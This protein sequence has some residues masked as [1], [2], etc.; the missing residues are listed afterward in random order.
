MRK[1]LACLTLVTLLVAGCAF[2]T[3]EKPQRMGTEPDTP[4]EEIITLKFGF[5]NTLD[6]RAVDVL[7]AAFQQA[8]PR[9]RVE[10]EEPK[11]HEIGHMPAMINHVKDR[12]FDLLDGSYWAWSNDYNILFEPLDT[13]VAKG[14]L[15]LQPCGGSDKAAL[16][17]GKLWALPLTRVPLV[18]VANKRLLEAEGLK[19]PEQ[20]WTWEQFRLAAGQL[21]H[22]QGD[23]KVWGFVTNLP[24]AM[25]QSW[26]EELSGKPVW[27]SDAQQ[28]GQA[29]QFFHSMA[30]T[31]RSVF[32]TP[33]FQRGHA[34]SRPDVWAMVQSGQAA[35]GLER[36]DTMPQGSENL[37]VLP[38]PA[39]DPARRVSPSYFSYVAMAVGT[40]KPDDAWKFIQFAL[41]PQGGEVLA[42]AGILPACPTE[43]ARDAWMRRSPAPPPATATFFTS[44]WTATT[45]AAGHMSY[46]ALWWQL[47]NRLMGGKLDPEQALGDY[48]EGKSNPYPIF[49]KWGT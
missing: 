9:Y 32:P 39:H 41:G 36:W 27:E 1:A 15:D 8:N 11:L 26:V 21:T 3:R 5:G 13:Y 12:K 43:A 22:G 29:M 40:V 4:T 30:A 49:Q 47:F 38:F 17:G 23:E 45:E 44:R 2:P 25:A 34:N 35:L 46:N 33:V 48:K 10:K 20:G 16:H 24:Q 28:I 42:T 31:D 7:I 19:V 6:P 18:L 14:A 37:V